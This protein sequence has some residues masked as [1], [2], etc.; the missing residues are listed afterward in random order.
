M[1]NCLVADRLSNWRAYEDFHKIT[2][3]IRSLECLLSKTI[4]LRKW[5]VVTYPGVA[6]S[7]GIV[8]D[9]LVL[10]LYLSIVDTPVTRMTTRN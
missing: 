7:S 8:D 6:I 9:I 3:L 1:K 5:H 4:N 10:K 2:K